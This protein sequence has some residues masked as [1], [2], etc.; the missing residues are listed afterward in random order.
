MFEF[1]VNSKKKRFKHH[2]LNDYKWL[3]YSESVDGAYCKMCV[4][5]DSDGGGIQLVNCPYKNW[6]NALANFKRHEKSNIHK[7][8]TAKYL[9]FNDT[10]VCK[11]GQTINLQLDSAARAQVETNRCKLKLICEAVLFCARQ[12][13]SLRGHRDDSKYY[14][15]RKNNPGNFQE[16]VNLMIKGRLASHFLMIPP[17]ILI[18]LGCQL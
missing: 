1:P 9:A 11:K 15:D 14:K 10:V 12:N 6:N 8:A 5:F 4:L 16:L 3:A 17:F 2:W 13:I 7:N 18:S